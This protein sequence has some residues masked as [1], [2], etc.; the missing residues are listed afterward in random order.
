MIERFFMG[1]EYI[2]LLLFHPLSFNNLDG[3]D[4]K[5]RGYFFVI[6]TLE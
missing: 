2:V 4:V 6:L 5:L 1:L 3:A